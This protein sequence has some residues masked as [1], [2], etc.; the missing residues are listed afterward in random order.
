MAS[1]FSEI[2]KHTPE[3]AQAVV[4]CGLVPYIAPLLSHLD[5]KLKREVISFVT[6]NEFHPFP[7]TP[8]TKIMSR[9]KVVLIF[10][11]CYVIKDLKPEMEF[12]AIGDPFG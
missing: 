8:T 12:K 6:E 11:A 1:A 5:Q 3:L 7:K 9:R 4:D 10:A 2:A